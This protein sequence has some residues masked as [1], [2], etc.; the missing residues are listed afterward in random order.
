MI[1]KVFRAIR[2]TLPV[3]LQVAIFRVRF[4]L[5]NPR[6]LS[7]Q[8]GYIYSDERQKFVH[9]LE[10][11]NY[12]RIAGVGGR[13]PPVYF[14]FGCH[15]GRT[16]SAAVRAARYLGMEDAD[17]FAFDSFE[18]LP[19]TN[20]AEDGFF[21][22]GTFFT[23]D[24]DF[25]RIVK[26]KTGLQ[27]DEKHVVKGFYSKSLTPQLQSSLPKV[28]VVHIDVDL[29]SSTVEVLEFIKPLMVVGTVLIFDDWYT[30]PPGADMGEMRAVREFC[31]ANPAFK[32][33]E[34]KAYS[35]FGK[36]FFVTAIP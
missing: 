25:A 2:G 5:K 17:F 14:E 24:V 6:L 26:R 32:L 9:I 33:E 1:K 29:Y 12:V 13:I 10:C 19:E 16:F 27:L 4:A 20:S 15:S 11:L 34:W 36:S 22:T 21:Q 35:T 23:T 8:S 3:F 7:T 28:G 18:G 31:Q 30:F